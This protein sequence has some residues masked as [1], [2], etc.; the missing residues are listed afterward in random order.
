[1]D[2]INRITIHTGVGLNSGSWESWQEV[3]ERQTET[4]IQ[5]E[6]RRHGGRGEEGNMTVGIPMALSLGN[7]L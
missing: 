6:T 4:E 7:S 3:R 2:C 5:R 1:M